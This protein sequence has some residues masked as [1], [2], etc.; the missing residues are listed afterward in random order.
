MAQPTQVTT[1]LPGGEYSVI[2]NAAAPSF[3]TL[4]ITKE[5]I[6]YDTTTGAV[7]QNA[8]PV[9]SGAGNGTIPDYVDDATVILNSQLS[10]R[11]L[12]INPA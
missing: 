5:H 8:T 3:P 11:L 1:G 9:L 6:G 4:D 10:T 7:G 2:D 12:Y